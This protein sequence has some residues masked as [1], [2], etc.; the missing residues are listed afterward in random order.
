MK[1]QLLR[2]TSSANK[3]P[4]SL[5]RVQLAWWMGFVLCAFV[6]IVFDTKN[7]DLALPTFTN[8]ILII[9]GISTG[10]TAAAAF[11][12]VSDQTNTQNTRHQDLDGT[13]LI[14]DILSDKD[15]ASV[16][17][18]QTVLFNLI[19][20]VWFFIKVWK[21]KTIPD[22]DPNAL[23]LLGLSSGT[24]A[25]LK[26]NENKSTADSKAASEA[27]KKENEIPPVG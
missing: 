15:G 14:L 13:N 19:F 6:A 12:D 3:K 20:A 2:D 5:S 8:G 11:T 22:L 17:R 25:V 26:T 9:L 21:Y 18:L 16:H 27:S 1:F 10:T 23:V 4:Y 7:Q 24:Y